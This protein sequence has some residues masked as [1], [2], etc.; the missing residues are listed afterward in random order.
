MSYVK[1]TPGQLVCPMTHNMSLYDTYD[2]ARRRL[3]NV[4][5]QLKGTGFIIATQR[6]NHVGKT[7]QLAYVM[8]NETQRMGWCFIE[9]LQALSRG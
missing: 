5:A 4:I 2:Y 3:I 6:I 1:F 8:D 9:Y 7:E